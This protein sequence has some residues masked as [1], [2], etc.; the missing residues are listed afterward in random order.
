MKIKSQAEKD[1]SPLAPLYER[2]VKQNEKA[3]PFCKGGQEGDF[4]VREIP[5]VFSSNGGMKSCL[6]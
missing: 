1:K 3:S 4:G 2:G 5:N 6:V